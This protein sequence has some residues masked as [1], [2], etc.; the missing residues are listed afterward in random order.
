MLVSS[1]APCTYQSKRQQDR[2]FSVRIWPIHIPHTSSKKVIGACVAKSSSASCNSSL[3]GHNQAF[4]GY[5]LCG[6]H[7]SL[8]KLFAPGGS[9]ADK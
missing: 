5:S 9:G 3:L 2:K 7:G 8:S 4:E 6:I 1:A